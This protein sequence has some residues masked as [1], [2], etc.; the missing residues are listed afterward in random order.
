MGEASFL[1]RA[2]QL[3]ASGQ[4]QP[5]HQHPT[6][7]I[8]SRPTQIAQREPRLELAPSHHQR[9]SLLHSAMLPPVAVSLAITF[10]VLMAFALAITCMLYCRGSKR[11]RA[12]NSDDLGFT[13]LTTIHEESDE[14][15]DAVEMQERSATTM[16]V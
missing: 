13:P 6:Q 16:T 10:A 5:F 7:G 8:V 15:G 4:A 11:R 2:A 9:L 14:E 12:L 1:M 3:C